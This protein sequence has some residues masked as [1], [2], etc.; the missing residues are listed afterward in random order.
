MLRGKSALFVVCLALGLAAPGCAVQ[1]QRTPSSTALTFEVQIAPA[2][3]LPP[4][5][6]RRPI[7]ELNFR[8]FRP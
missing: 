2:L 1:P 8:I 4:Q 5:D 3:R 7:D 6:G